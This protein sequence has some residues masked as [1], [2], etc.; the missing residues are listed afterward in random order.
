MH[1][2][3][4]LDKVNEIMTL[5]KRGIREGREVMRYTLL[6]LLFSLLD[7]FASKRNPYASV[8]YKKL[9]FL[10]IENHNEL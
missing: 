5:I 1:L 8:V 9:T 10:F 4:E 2:E 3:E 6:E 7:E